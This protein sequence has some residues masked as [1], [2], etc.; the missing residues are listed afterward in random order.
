MYALMELR[1][2]ISSSS[3]S[4]NRIVYSASW[5][6]SDSSSLRLVNLTAV[7]MLLFSFRRSSAS[8][9]SCLTMVRMVPSDALAWFRPW[10]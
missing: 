6:L 8:L 4:L 1:R 2:D 5:S 9:R 7:L 10:L 3:A